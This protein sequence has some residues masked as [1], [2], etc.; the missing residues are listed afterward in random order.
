MEIPEFNTK[1]SEKA[2]INIRP[3]YILPLT[4]EQDLADEVNQLVVDN[5]LRTF[6]EVALART[7]RSPV[8]ASSEYGKKTLSNSCEVF[9]SKYSRVN[10]SPP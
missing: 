8:C 6:S 9:F 1:N 3:V 7:G 10:L 4:P 5:F 2:L